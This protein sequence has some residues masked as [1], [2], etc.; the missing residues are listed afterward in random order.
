M[1]KNKINR[2]F[3][4]FGFEMHGLGYLKKIS[5]NSLENDAYEV[6]R[7]ILKDKEVRIIEL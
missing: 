3:K 2:I 1:M 7:E 4:K 5:K 6:Q